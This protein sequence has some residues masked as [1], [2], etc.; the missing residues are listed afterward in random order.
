MIALISRNGTKTFF[1]FYIVPGR[2]MMPLA[3]HLNVPRGTNIY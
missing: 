2:I 3:L 1:V